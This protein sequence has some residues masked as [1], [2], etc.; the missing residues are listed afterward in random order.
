MIRNFARAILA[1]ATFAILALPA[2]AHVTLLVGEAHIGGGYK[3]VLRIPHGCDGS[4]TVGVKVKLP[5]GFIN[6]K[7]QPKA[8]WVLDI[9]KGNYAKTYTLYGSDVTKGALEVSWSGGNLP[10]DQYDEF[11]VNGTLAADLDITKP[12][13]FAIIQTCAEGETAWI[14]VTGNPDSEPAASLTLLPALEA[15]H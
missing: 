15:K 1:T 4:A 10:D 12:L 5:E 3:A 9:Q 8:G 14:D 2:Y 6:A 13:F 7:P 11:A